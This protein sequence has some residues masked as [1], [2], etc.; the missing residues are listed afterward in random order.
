MKKELVNWYVKD[1]LFPFLV[2]LALI[3]TAKLLRLNTLF[4]ASSLNFVV[5]LCFLGLLYVYL[6]PELRELFLRILKL[7]QTNKERI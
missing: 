3:G 6:M 2:S 4:F 1:N 7:K 5:L